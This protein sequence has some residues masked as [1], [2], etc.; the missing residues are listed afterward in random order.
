MSQQYP[1]KPDMSP[2]ALPPHGADPF[3]PLHSEP[4]TPQM[5]APMGP[6]TKDEC[7]MAMLAHLLVRF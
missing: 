6:P 3:V 7:T 5:G 1:P 2:D 4:K